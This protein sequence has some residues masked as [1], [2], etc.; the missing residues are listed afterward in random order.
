MKIPACLLIAIN[1]V[2]VLIPAVT[3]AHSGHGDR[4]V[5]NVLHQVIYHASN[6]MTLIIL[7]LVLIAGLSLRIFL[8]K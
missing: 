6:N 3:L 4:S 7:L 5:S 8:N 1:A 2:A